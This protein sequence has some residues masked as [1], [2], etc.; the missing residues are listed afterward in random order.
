MPTNAADLPTLDLVGNRYQD[1]SDASLL[2]RDYGSGTVS[3]GGA[4]RHR[5]GWAN[6][7]TDLPRGGLWD[8]AQNAKDNDV[9]YLGKLNPG[10]TYTFWLL[11][12]NHDDT[13]PYDSP[14]DYQWPGISF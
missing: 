8:D 3:V 5:E 13:V 14:Y 12:E 10:V 7:S 4:T 11:T 2:V 6:A 1:A 9:Y